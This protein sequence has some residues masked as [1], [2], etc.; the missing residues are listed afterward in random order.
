MRVARRTPIVFVVKTSVF[1]YGFYPPTVWVSVLCFCTACA[2]FLLAPCVISTRSL[3]LHYIPELPTC[4]C[5]PFPDDTPGSGCPCCAGYDGHDGCLCCEGCSGGCRRC[6]WVTTGRF[7]GLTHLCAMLC[8]SL[9]VAVFL[10]LY[11]Y[12]RDGS[13]LTPLERQAGWSL[14]GQIAQHDNATAGQTQSESTH[15]DQTGG[16]NTV[17]RGSNPDDVSNTEETPTPAES[18]GHFETGVWPEVSFWCLLCVLPTCL[19][20]LLCAYVHHR[21]SIP[22]KQNPPIVQLTDFSTLSRNSESLLF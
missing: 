11:I 17:Q 16:S 21:T 19:V 13:V 7:V 22:R 6:G 4:T 15:R 12:V 5:Y 2:L 20:A 9:M 3:L 8:V 10:V 14:S 18:G 1:E